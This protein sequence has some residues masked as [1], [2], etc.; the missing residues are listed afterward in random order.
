MRLLFFGR[1]VTYKGLGQLLNAY[2]I[3]RERGIAVELDIVGSGNLAA[4]ASQ[5]IGLPDVSIANAWVDEDQIAQVLAR[6]D[7]VILPYIEA[8][9][10]GVAAAALTAGLPIVA[11]PVGGLTE[12]VRCGQTGV[13]AKGLGPEHLAAAIQRL[14]ENPR[15]YETCSAG[16]LRHA[17]EELAWTSVAAEVARIVK[18]VSARNSRRGRQ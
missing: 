14:V 12:Q 15:L 16:A 18:E 2:R 17:R 11:T 9:Q 13:I 8:S 5:L 3:L 10:S 1:I 6:S 4:Y 7:L